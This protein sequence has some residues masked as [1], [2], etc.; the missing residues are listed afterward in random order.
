M[1]PL[2]MAVSIANTVLP[3]L[4]G[5]SPCFLGPGS[6]C[7]LLY[8]CEALA[9]G[10][11]RDMRIVGRYRSTVGSQVASAVSRLA[12]LPFS[13]ERNKSCGLPH[14]LSG[15]HDDCASKKNKKALAICGVG[16]TD[17]V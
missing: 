6:L 16:W 15:M 8:A 1:N 2:C 5:A 14:F 3:L 4:A 9:E 7:P 12:R 13:R 17:E 10:S 11:V